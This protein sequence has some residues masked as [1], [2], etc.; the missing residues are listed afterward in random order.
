MYKFFNGTENSISKI[1]K[2]EMEEYLQNNSQYIHYK[3]QYKTPEYK[4]K[5][6]KNNL[7]SIRENIHLRPFY[8]DKCK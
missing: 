8:E 4:P 1:N 5:I 7:E 2:K 3:N 6:K